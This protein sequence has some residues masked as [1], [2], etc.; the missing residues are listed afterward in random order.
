MTLPMIRSTTHPMSRFMRRFDPFADVDTLYE[1]MSQFMQ[2]MMGD[3][4][5]L[6]TDLEET[7]DAYI[8]EMDV[9]GVKR[10]DVN[11]E[12]RDSQLQV[13]GEVKERKRT[14][15]LRRQSRPVG[16]FECALSLPG[17]IDPEGVEATLENGVL[18]VMLPKAPEGRPRQIEIKS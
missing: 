10:E 13:T 11:V 5:T 4:P 2:R 1:D 9:P 7:D 8:V 6:P 14:G 3:L 17:E 15:T 12:I 18:T 16:K